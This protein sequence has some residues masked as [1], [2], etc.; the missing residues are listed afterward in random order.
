MLGTTVC[1]VRSFPFRPRSAADLEVGDFWTVALPSGGLGVLQVRDLKSSGPGSRSVL[2]AGVVDWRGYAE[3]DAGDLRGRRVL[4][5][6]LTRIEAFTDG[7]AAV[8]GNTTE[9]VPTAGLTSSFR[10]FG[11]GTVT[12]VWGWKAL[13]RRTEQ[14]LQ[15]HE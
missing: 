9:T 13:P 2:V 12:H 15:E 11:V 7:A 5:Q 6:G 3:P 10:D 14:V 4:A 8:L 1:P